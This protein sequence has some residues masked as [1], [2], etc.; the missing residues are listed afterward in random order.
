M[1]K[2]ACSHC[3]KAFARRF[4]LKEHTRIHTG[5]KPF[6]CQWPGCGKAFRT[7]SNLKRHTLKHSGGHGSGRDVE[8]RILQVRGHWTKDERAAFLKIRAHT[9][10]GPRC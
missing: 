3:N 9:L 2:H 4:H 7:S 8:G 1:K 6:V 5:E 10:G